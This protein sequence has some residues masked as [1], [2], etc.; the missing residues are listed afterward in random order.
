VFKTP[1]SHQKKKKRKDYIGSWDY[2][3]M[4]IILGFRQRG[5]D[6]EFEVILGY[7]AKFSH[8]GLHS[9]ALLT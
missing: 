8:Y 6:H 2:G 7:I 4:P 5:E 9:E 1:Q 3:C